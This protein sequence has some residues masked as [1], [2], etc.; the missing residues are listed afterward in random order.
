MKKPWLLFLVLS[1]A[2]L[3]G[4]GA[5]AQTP[6]SPT[7]GSRIVGQ[8]KI[9][10]ETPRGTPPTDL[11]GP[12]KKQLAAHGWKADDCSVAREGL[13]VYKKIRGYDQGDDA[14]GRFPEMEKKIVEQ[15]C[16]VP[17]EADNIFVAEDQIA[18]CDAKP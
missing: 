15:E 11:T 6:P 4:G 3:I 17:A 8:I 9:T 7:S 5:Q 12:F 16:K 1:V 18:K 14:Q 2:L 10:L 13:Q